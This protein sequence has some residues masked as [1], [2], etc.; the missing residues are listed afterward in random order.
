MKKQL[1]SMLCL[2]TLGATNRLNAQATLVETP[3][4]ESQDILRV[5]E[6]NGSLMFFGRE[7]GGSVFD[8]YLWSNNGTSSTKIL[9]MYSFTSGINAS[10]ITPCNGKGFFFTSN[11]TNGYEPWVTDGTAAG[12]FMLKDINTS[13]NSVSVS[14]EC[15]C[16]G[17][18][19]YFSAYDATAGTELWTSDGTTVGTTM[20]KDIKVGTGNADPINFLDYNSEVYFFAKSGN[21]NEL[22]HTNGTTAG[23]SKMTN[24]AGLF[25]LGATMYKHNNLLF[26]SGYDPSV[27][28]GLW[29]TDGTTAGTSFIATASPKNFISLGTDLLFYNYFMDGTCFCYRNRLYKT[30]GTTITMIKDSVTFINPVLLGSKVVFGGEFTNSNTGY[31]P[32]VTDGTTVGTFSLGNVATGSASS[33]FQQYRC[34]SQ[35]YNNKIYFPSDLSVWE[36]DGTVGGTIQNCDV[37][38]GSSDMLFDFATLGSTLYFNAL[39]PANSNRAELFKLGGSAGI[40]ENDGFKAGIS[41]YPQ[42]AKETITL[43]FNSDVNEIEIHLIDITGKELKTETLEALDNKIQ[44]NVG[45]IAEGMYFL[46]IKTPDGKTASG[47]IVI[48]K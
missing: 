8:V 6:V 42:P 18:K 20:L 7:Q 33:F 32:W 26:F 27:N 35:P 21:Y 43:A 44:L 16:S 25:K 12:T 24:P 1:L 17:N 4:I 22:W 5:S 11:G 19:F 31:E 34:I 3:G 45:N 36:T 15:F 30:N 47:K 40:N 38:P 28:E 29:K 37:K 10:Y 14:Q 39:N 23:T 9:N 2:L 13:G 48:S 41:I 46:Q